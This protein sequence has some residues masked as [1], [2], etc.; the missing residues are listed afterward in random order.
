MQVVVHQ[1]N[2]TPIVKSEFTTSSRKE[3]REYSEIRLECNRI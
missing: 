2:T 3:E 1:E